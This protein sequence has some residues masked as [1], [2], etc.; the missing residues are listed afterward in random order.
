MWQNIKVYN[1]NRRH[2]AVARN[3]Y[4]KIVQNLLQSSHVII[5]LRTCRVAIYQNLDNTDILIDM[6]LLYVGI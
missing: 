5:Y 1:N 2:V 6:I 4:L 3:L